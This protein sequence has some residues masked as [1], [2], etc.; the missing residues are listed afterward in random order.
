MTQKE[1]VVAHVAEVIQTLGVKSVRMDD[2]AQ[3]LGMSKRTLYEMFGDKEELIYESARYHSEH[4]AK[5]ILSSLGHYD[6]GIEQLLACSY[7]LLNGGV[8]LEV[9]KRMAINLK[10]FYPAIHERLSRCHIE[11]SFAGLQCV[12]DY[13]M[14]NGEL[15]PSVDVE[16]MTRLFFNTMQTLLYENTAV[17]PDEITREEAFSAMLINFLRGIASERG[18]E[19]ID[20]ILS[21]SPRPLTLAE[22]RAAKQNKE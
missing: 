9:D 20:Q 8:M 2:V 14:A 22:R 16:L 5:E 17:I 4:R 12:L 19:I 13:S 15:D 11:Q 6:T 1:K 7:A 3:S 10:K 21:R 18:R